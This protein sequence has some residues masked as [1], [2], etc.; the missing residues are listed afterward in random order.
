MDDPEQFRAVSRERWEAAARGWSA[1]REAFQS[2]ATPVSAWLVDAVGPEPGQTILELAAGPGDTGLLAAERVR[3][4]G[5]VILTDGAEAMVEVA[6]ARAEELGLSGLVEV[7]PMEAEWIDLPT[8][9]AD[10]VLCRWGYMLLADPEAALRETRR[11]LRPGGRV[12]LAV[13]DTPAANPWSMGGLLLD[14]GVV[15]PRDP[16]EPGPFALADPGRVRDLLQDAGFGE[17]VVDAVDFAFMAPDADA[18]WAQQLDCSPT[19]SEAVR[20]LSPADHYK[21]RDAVDAFLEDFTQ[22]DGSLR[23]PARTLA[24]SA[25]A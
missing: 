7:R 8:A 14:L 20:D 16:G 1:R 15:E 2:A 19:L 23:I 18:W 17:V 4:D 13:W 21:L 10:G 6:K 24:A 22:P 9:S 3:P 12:A 25:T 5:K 11:V